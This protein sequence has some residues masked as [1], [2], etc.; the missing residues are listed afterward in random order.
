MPKATSAVSVLVHSAMLGHCVADPSDAQLLAWFVTDRDEEAFAGL[1]NRHGA[2]VL[3]V[4]RRVTGDAHLAEDAFQAV[5]LVLARRA[6]EVNPGSS[7]RSWLY[8]VAVR[9]AKDA[10]T[11]A[12]RRRV[13]ETSVPVVPDRPEPINEL[14]DSE[15]LRVLDEEIGRLPDHLRAAVIFFEIDGLSRRDTA[16]RLG[17]PEGTLASRLGKARKV[18]GY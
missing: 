3:A 15:I 17:I 18:L 7:L 16:A 12:F 8:G 6:A 11:T 10:R 9:T 13:R 4:C 2:M 14:P 5:F 1:V